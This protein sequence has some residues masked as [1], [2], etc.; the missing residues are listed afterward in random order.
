M[1]LRQVAAYGSSIF[2]R[3]VE[4]ERARRA[5]PE[6]RVDEVEDSDTAGK[7]DE[8]SR[9]APRWFCFATGL[10]VAGQLSRLVIVGELDRRCWDGCTATSPR[11][12]FALFSHG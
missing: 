12:G 9:K 1:S 3:V 8:P 10:G 5:G 6:S 4:G 2:S 7:T 11:L